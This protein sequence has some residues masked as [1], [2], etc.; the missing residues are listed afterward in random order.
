MRRFIGSMRSVGMDRE[1]LWF[2]RLAMVGL[3]SG[4]VNDPKA[5]R[6]DTSARGP[7]GL[8]QVLLNLRLDGVEYGRCELRAPWAVAFPAQDTARIHFVGR[9]DCWLRGGAGDWVALRQ[10][11]AVLLPRGT[12]HLVASSPDVPAVDIG[13]LPR[14]AVADAI[15]LVGARH[16]GA[17]GATHTMFCA[18]LR[19]NLD[20]R[21]PLLALMPDVIRAS[22]LARRDPTV[23]T[24]L[25]AMEREVTQQRV[26]A[27]AVLARMADVLAAT[28][29]RAWAEC[30][31]GETS[32]WM[33]ALR[34]PVVGKA[35]AAI[36]ADPARDWSV[37]ALAGLG[38]SSRSAFATA[39]K[40]RV[41]ETPSRY[42]ARLRMFQASAWIAEEGMRVST[43]ADRLGYESEASFSR[44]YKRIMG[45]P[46]SAARRQA[47]LR[48]PAITG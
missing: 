9:G 12:A 33:A 35:L 34:C 41:G 6:L 38:G 17:A 10:G 36:H 44:A 23:P 48:T 46:P 30:L 43:A 29:I 13:S 28:T 42:V 20:A 16:L 18:G 4:A 45:V 19:F 39:F 11:D 22:D 3:A 47:G 32:G 25:E 15:D 26:G 27:C 14:V 2:V 24:L 1:A 5:K 31:C 7:D 40:A 8:A 37:P 21:H